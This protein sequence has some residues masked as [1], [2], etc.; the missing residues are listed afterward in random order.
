M[1]FYLFHFI[2]QHIYLG[3]DRFRIPL[4]KII[5]PFFKK[6]FDLTAITT[7]VVV[8]LKVTLPAIL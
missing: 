1:C 6:R 3:W 4:A 2:Q 8:N 5:F 7:R